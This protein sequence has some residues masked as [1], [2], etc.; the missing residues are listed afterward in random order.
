[1]GQNTMGKG[2]T[3]EAFIFDLDGTLVY[4][5][6]ELR[7]KLLKKPLGRSG[8]HPDP[9]STEYKER[10]NRFWFG[11]NRDNTL[12]QWGIKGGDELSRFW[13]IYRKGDKIRLRRK[14]AR[15]YEDVGF[16][17][18]L[19]ERG[20]KT[21]VV[22]GAPEHIVD[23]YFRKLLDREW[24]NSVVIAGSEEVR[25]KPEPYVIERCIEALGVGKE[26]VIYIGNSEEDM[27]TGSAA[28][29]TTVL[30]DRGE[31]S[32]YEQK[33]DMDVLSLWELEMFFGT[34]R[35]TDR[36]SLFKPGVQII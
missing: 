15:P 9:E 33:P 35:P 13:R 25:P 11:Y 5:P 4:T 1:M 29:V 30:V 17:Q 19:R 23:F 24:F 16:I 26:S 2:K 7:H 3:Y 28:G 8:I 14:Y 34:G 21:G 27:L 36:E 31:C 10:V 32:V 6:F 20:K 22:T 18:E 12:G